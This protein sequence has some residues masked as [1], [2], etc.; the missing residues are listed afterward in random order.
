MKKLYSLE[1]MGDDAVEE[2]EKIDIKESE[3]DTK[4]SEEAS[5]MISLKALV[6]IQTLADYNTM[7]VSGSVKRHK[8]HILIDSGSTHNFIDIFTAK[9]LGCEMTDHSLRLW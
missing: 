9:Q 4:S 1:L 8:V 2:E 3:L 6:G 7:R 5:V